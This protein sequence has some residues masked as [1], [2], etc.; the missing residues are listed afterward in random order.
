MKKRGFVL[1][2]LMVLAAALAGCAS[3]PTPTAYDPPGFF[4]A[5]LHGFTAPFALFGGIFLDV[6]VY[7]FPNSGWL[8]DLGFMLGLLPWGGAAA[9]R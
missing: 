1:L 3:Q 2:G 5:L 4:M 9:S 8:Y 6:R 7:A